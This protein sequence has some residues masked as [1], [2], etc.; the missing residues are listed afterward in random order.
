MTHERE[1]R[2]RKEK[3]KEKKRS[4]TYQ[5]L[6]F[7]F[8]DPLHRFCFLFGQTENNQEDVESKVQSYDP[9][10]LVRTISFHAKFL[11]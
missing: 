5:H 10:S 1:K 11:T 4:T 3:E 9:P 2:E 6:P 7:P 8:Q